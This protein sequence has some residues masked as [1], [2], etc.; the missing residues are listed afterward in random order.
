MTGTINPT[1]PVTG[2]PNSTADPKVLGSLK[3]LRD[4]INALLN[5]ENKIL[6]SKIEKEG[7]GAEQL[8]PAAKLGRWYTPK[9]IPTEESREN[10][11]FGTLTTA[12]EIK[13]VVLPEN[14]LML[15]GYRARAKSSVTGQ[16]S[17]CI[18]L[19][20][21][22]LKSFIGESSE[23]GI[24]GTTW[25][26][27]FTSPELTLQATPEGE[28]ADASTGQVAAFVLLPVFAA[29]ATYDVSVR[30]KAASGKVTAKE[31]KLWVAVLGA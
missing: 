22:Q 7:I 17:A 8:A 1:L 4:E 10:A 20:N 23:R 21:N 30:W 9:I 16:G 28:T 15:I 11:A 13:N 25:K 31:R 24:G 14:G 26:Y 6:G 2:E 12:D 27:L 29:A 18:F 3:T 19:G 5:S